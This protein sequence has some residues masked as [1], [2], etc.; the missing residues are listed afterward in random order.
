MSKVALV[1]GASSGIGAAIATTLAATAHGIIPV[2]MDVTDDPT[3]V[4]GIRGIIAEQGRLDALVN[5]AG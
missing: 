3:M 4:A 1:T 5:N 2:P